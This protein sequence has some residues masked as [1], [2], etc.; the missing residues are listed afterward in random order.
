MPI[1]IPDCQNSEYTWARKYEVSGSWWDFNKNSVSSISSTTGTTDSSGIEG[2]DYEADCLDYDI[3]WEDLVIGEQVGQGCCGTVY[4]AL[5]HGSDMAAKV[6][7]KQEYS[8]EMINTLRQEGGL[9]GLHG[10]LRARRV[11]D[12]ADHRR[13]Q[14]RPQGAAPAGVAGVLAQSQPCR[15]G[16]RQDGG[17]LLSKRQFIPSGLP[18]QVWALLL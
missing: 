16:R 2:V 8:E 15:R 1:L 5:W 12:K 13:R 14:H 18:E 7:S 9:H 3:L 17:P 4:H 6:F 11:H 10:V